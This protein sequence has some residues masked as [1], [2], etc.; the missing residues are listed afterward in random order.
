MHSLKSF[1][2]ESLNGT[3]KLVILGAG[4]CLKADDAAG[5]EIAERLIKE[6]SENCSD[7]LRVYSG[8]TAPEN[9]SGAIKSFG[10]DHL[11]IID[12][13]DF[14]EAPGE[15][16]AIDP[17]VI[18]GIS[19]STHMLPLKIFIQY[20]LKETGCKVTVIGVQP[21]NLSLDSP[22][23]PPVKKAVSQLLKALKESLSEAGLL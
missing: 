22:M 1:F 8:S 20:L 15:V 16:S 11:I 23:S 7:R 3:Q 14:G 17:E 6:Y 4:S 18:A 19:F 2:K 9:Y 13:A 5:V 21:Q 12:A 10:A